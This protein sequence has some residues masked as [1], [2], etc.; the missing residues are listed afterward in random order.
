MA[1][2][3][4]GANTENP[5]SKQVVQLVID[6]FRHGVLHRDLS[7]ENFIRGHRS[8]QLYIVDFSLAYLRPALGRRAHARQ[9]KWLVGDGNE[10]LA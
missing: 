7:A 5:A 3:S 8:Q 2:Q 6:T 9:L 1:N 4:L 10:D